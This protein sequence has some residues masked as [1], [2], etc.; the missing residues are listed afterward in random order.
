MTIGYQELEAKFGRTGFKAM[1]DAL[2]VFEVSENWHSPLGR[3]GKQTATKRY[4]LS[5]RVQEL[6]AKYLKPRLN[7]AEKLV[8]LDSKDEMRPLKSVLNPIAAKEQ[9]GDALGVTAT[10][11]RNA[12]VFS[13]V[14]VDLDRLKELYY[15][16]EKLRKPENLRQD[17]LFLRAEAEATERSIE[18]VGILIRLAQTDIAGRGF[19]MHR[20]AE[21]ATGRLYARG[22][23]LQTA[24]KRIRKV[25]LHGLWDYD[26]DNCHFSIF[27]QLAARYGYHAHAVR[28]YLAHKDEVRE[29]IASRIGI[30]KDRGAK[31]ALLALMFGARTNEHYET[32]IPKVIGMDKA[33]LL[34]QDREFAALAKDV[35]AGRGVILKAW[36][37][38]RNTLQNDLGKSADLYVKPK[39][40]EPKPKRRV[41]TKPEILM[42]HIIQGIEAKAIRAAI[43]LYPDDIALLMHDGFVATRS[44]DLPLVER[45]MFEETDYRLSLS[46]EVVQIPADL[47]YSK[48]P[49]GYD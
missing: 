46:C 2:H 47:D 35:Q 38:H 19:I 4:Q 29:G 22:Y 45:R 3:N 31:M 30:D 12:K 34:Y 10:A 48:I 7:L 44:I 42:A 8:Y 25:A 43:E 20:Y 26:I 18:W 41:A 9:D 14:P 15:Y 36:P 28:H 49:D 16:L 33:R 17:D 40:G 32:A 27:E 39:E 11:W 6:K 1:N 5:H 21:C 24:P 13:K 37:K 23:S